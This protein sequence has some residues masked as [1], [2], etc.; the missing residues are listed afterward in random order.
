MIY[1][2]SVSNA[3][4]VFNV[5]VVILNNSKASRSARVYRILCMKITHDK[6]SKGTVNSSILPFYTPSSPSGNPGFHLPGVVLLSNLP[7]SH[8]YCKIP[9]KQQENNGK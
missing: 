3:N 7:H 1:E 2:C 4:N 8:P 6:T 9:G 5:R